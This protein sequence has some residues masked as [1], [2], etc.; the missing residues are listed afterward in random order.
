M[1]NFG[2]RILAILLSG[3][4]SADVTATNTLVFNYTS[5]VTSD[6]DGPLDLTAELNFSSALSHAPV[7]VMMHP[8]SDL[9]GQYAAYRDNAIRFRDKGF[10]FITPAMRRREGGDGVRDNGGVELQ[11]VHDAVEAVKAAF[12]SRI[13]P[14]SI[15]IT[16]YSGGGGNTMSALTKFPDYFNAA[17]AYFGMSD[18]GFDTTSGW[19]FKGAGANHRSILN[20]APGNSTP[21]SSSDIIDRYHARAS[22]LAS[23]NNPYTEIHLFV[24]N[25]ETVCP[26][27]NSTKFKSNA[28]T[29]AVFAGEFD[30]IAVHIG[31]PTLYQDFNGNRINDPNELQYWPHGDPTA[32]QQHG[33]GAWFLD[34]LLA[35]Q[36]PA[37]ELNAQDTLYVTG[38]V[39][40]KRFALWLGDGQNAA[41]DL[42]YTLSPFKKTFATNLKSL[43]PVNGRL[44]IDT[45]DMLGKVVQVKRNGTVIRTRVASARFTFPALADDDLLELLVATPPG[46][47]VA[48]IAVKSELSQATIT[49]NSEAGEV[50]DVFRSVD[51]N[52]PEPAIATGIIGEA[53]FT[54]YLDTAFSSGGKAF[55]RVFRR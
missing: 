40:T 54:N 21:P 26:K 41:A 5:T 47:F 31:L 8:F 39:R 35:G 43:L 22:N 13:N 53:G 24:N 49:W 37:P 32:N 50:F 27:I 3:G 2:S 15:S 16:G 14:A 38:F 42:I 4:V 25:D 29:A 55:Y 52:F 10:F 19:Y 44:E 18:Y 23:K 36:I 45:A 9:T 11:D 6:A 12:P 46:A 1:M 30:N 7:M 51:L 28:E 48:H 34:R 20:A 17:S 33:G